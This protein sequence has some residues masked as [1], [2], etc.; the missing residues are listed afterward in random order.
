MKENNIHVSVEGDVLTIRGEKE[1]ESEIKEGNYYRSELS[2]GSVF[3]SVA[4]PSIV[5]A[6]KIVA[7][8]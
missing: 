8:S 4:L 5:D 2:H 3:R 1:T 6:S 7:I